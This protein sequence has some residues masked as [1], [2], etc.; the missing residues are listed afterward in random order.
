MDGEDVVNS[1]HIT[2]VGKEGCHDI[3][4]RHVSDHDREEEKY[5]L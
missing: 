2:F 5:V 3:A 1:N 4:I